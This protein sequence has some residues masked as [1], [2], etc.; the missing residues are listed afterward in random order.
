M[1]LAFL[2]TGTGLMRKLTS[3]VALAASIL[4]IGAIAAA[5]YTVKH[6]EDVAICPQS[7]APAQVVPNNES[8]IAA[9]VTARIDSIPAKVG[10]SV[11]KGDVLVKLDQRQHKLALDQA[12]NRL[13][14]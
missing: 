6:L 14:C 11:S 9:E 3:M 12:R 10:Q 2:Q 7:S 13:N 8:R 1:M 5:S 4:S